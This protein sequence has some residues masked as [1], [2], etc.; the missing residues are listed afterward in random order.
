MHVGDVGSVY[1]E[2]SFFQILVLPQKKLIFYKEFSFAKY[3]DW[4]S[5]L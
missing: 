4:I 2:G 5:R 1:S 3:V